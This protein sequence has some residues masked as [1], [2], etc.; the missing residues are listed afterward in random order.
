MAF[1][2]SCGVMAGRGTAGAP[3]RGPRKEMYWG[4][5]SRNLDLAGVFPYSRRGSP[6]I[7]LEGCV[8]R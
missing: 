3:S 6:G 7:K 8:E 2:A 1:L 5:M 4:Q